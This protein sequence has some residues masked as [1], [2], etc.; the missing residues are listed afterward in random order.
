MLRNRN[1]WFWLLFVV[2]VSLLFLVNMLPMMGVQVDVAW[3]WITGCI[4]GPLAL[5]GMAFLLIRDKGETQ[6][7]EEDGKSS[8]GWAGWINNDGNLSLLMFGS[9]IGLTSLVRAFDIGTVP[10][11]IIGLVLIALFFAILF[12]KLVGPPRRLRRK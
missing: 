12:V 9:L 11:T 6:A 7:E 1:F 5:A 8:Q 4:V 2:P 10:K 3:F